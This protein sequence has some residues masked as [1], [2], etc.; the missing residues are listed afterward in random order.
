MKL[1]TEQ[2]QG[3]YRLAY[4]LT[5][6]GLR[7]RLGCGMDRLHAI[8][9][10]A[11]L[12]DDVATRL[13][14]LLAEPEVNRLCRCGAPIAPTRFGK[15]QPRLCPTCQAERQAKER[16]ARNE[17]KQ[18]IR[19]ARRQE[20]RCACGAPV[21]TPRGRICP[22]CQDA[23]RALERMGRQK[24]EAARAARRQER[25]GTCGA[26]VATPMSRHC[27][28]HSNAHAPAAVGRVSTAAAQA[29]QCPR[30]GGPIGRDG[31]LAFCRR[32]IACGWVE[33]TSK[34]V[35]AGGVP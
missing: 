30:C 28:A 6:K 8:R 5:W 27:H 15:A 17:R 26:P 4:A 22:T 11:D 3:V 31:V 21:A 34:A 23:S 24:R 10:G 18:A 13:I 19:A 29:Q 9:S 25:Q 14:A 35:R 1:T 7:E 33:L 2:R 12:P 20:R 16:A 32:R